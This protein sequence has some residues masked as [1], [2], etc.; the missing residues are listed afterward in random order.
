M[1]R[2]LL[3]ALV[4][5][6]AALP[7]QAAVTMTFYSREFGT[8][9]PHAFVAM[10]GTLDGDGTVV[11]GSWG[12]TAVS[13][14][15][16]ILM[17]SVPGKLESVTDSYRRG[18]DAHFSVVLSDAQYA[19][20]HRVIDDWRTRGGKSYNL[21]RANCVHFVGEL[22]RAAGLVA[23]D[24]PELMKKPRSYLVAVKA[25]NPQLVSD[26]PQAVAAQ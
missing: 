13:I 8:S 20:V 21:N 25:A 10:S 2:R 23:V 14:T 16:A 5:L 17:G 3:L 15:P 19:A 6:V 12:F 22:A 26:A 18:S 24:D 9:F 11:E 4:L 7:A 1:F